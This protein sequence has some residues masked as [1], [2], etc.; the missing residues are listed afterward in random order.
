MAR[1][2]VALATFN[3][4]GNL[5]D[6][7][8]SVKDIADEITIVDGSSSDKTVEIAKKYGAKVLVTD[9]HPIFHI[10]KQKALDMATNEWILQLD[11]DERVTPALAYEIKKVIAMTDK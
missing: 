4:E 7:L 8:E 11:A 5:G 3:E 6:C 10:N 9:N 1:L 2:T